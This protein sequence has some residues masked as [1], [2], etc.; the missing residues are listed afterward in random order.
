MD[1]DATREGRGI[2]SGRT[3]WVCPACKVEVHED[4]AS[5]ADRYCEEHAGFRVLMLRM[6]IRTGEL[7]RGESG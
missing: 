1:S 2:V 3:V 4:G 6:T 7:T 5:T